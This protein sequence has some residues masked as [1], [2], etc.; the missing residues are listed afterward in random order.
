M[1][2]K[3]NRI[4]LDRLLRAT[5]GGRRDLSCD[6]HLEDRRIQAVLK[7]ELYRPLRQ[8]SAFPEEA[9]G[10]PEYLI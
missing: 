10:A 7:G 4:F 3:E 2:Q 1:T 6:R 9:T 8:V 5:P